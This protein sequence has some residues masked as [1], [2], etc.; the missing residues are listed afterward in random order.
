MAGDDDLDWGNTS[1]NTNTDPFMD[2]EDDFFSTPEEEE[3]MWQDEPL[4]DNQGIDEQEVFTKPQQKSPLG[5][6]AVAGIIVGFLILLALVLTIIDKVSFTKKPAQPPTEAQQQIQQ[7]QNVN[8]T[9][10]TQGNKNNQEDTNP[11]ENSDFSDKGG[12]GDTFDEEDEVE[13]PKKSKI[14][15]ENSKR[16]NEPE[17]TT[18]GD[19]TEV[20]ASVSADYSGD[21]FESEG[22]ISS[23]TRYL[24][25]GQLVYCLEIDAEIG[26]ET[27]TVKYYCGY[28][29]FNSVS[30]GDTVNVTYQVVSDTTYSVNTIT[31]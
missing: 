30:K 13:V 27:R 29:T 16:A 2:D 26:D 9:G 23:K 24:E 17:E 22:L 6:K 21:V 11:V 1:D 19:M 10:G 25:N 18:Q 8:N 3:Q 7:E 20:P 14:N 31:K 15:T 12:N 5:F 28:N 4:P